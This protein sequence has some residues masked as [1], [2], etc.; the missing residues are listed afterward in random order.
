MRISIRFIPVVMALLSAPLAP[1]QIETPKSTFVIAVHPSNKFKASTSKTKN[2]IRRLYLKEWATWPNGSTVRAF[3]R[4]TGS[5][6]QDRFKQSILA[7]TSA[8]IARHWL[9][10]KNLAGLTPPKA[11]SSDRLMV[12]YVKKYPGA[13][14]II[15]RDVAEKN[16]LRVLLAL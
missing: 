8:E 13:F 9:S 1:R 11:V 4:K 16:G 12:K 5:A 7:M 6:E 10:K 3:G 15:R 14:A 2:T